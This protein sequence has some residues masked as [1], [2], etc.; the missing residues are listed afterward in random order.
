[1]DIDI[2]YKKNI[3]FYNNDADC[4]IGA[5]LLK[6]YIKNNIGTTPITFKMKSGDRY[7]LEEVDNNTTIWI[8]GLSIQEEDMEFMNRYTSKVKWFFNNDSLIKTTLTN[9]DIYNNID[10]YSH[11]IHNKYYT[12]QNKFIDDFVKNYKYYELIINNLSDVESLY[13]GNLISENEITLFDNIRDRISYKVM[14]NSYKKEYEKYTYYIIY[15]NCCTEDVIEKILR[16][17]DTIIVTYTITKM[18]VINYK[19]YSNVYDLEALSINVGGTIT[20]NIVI[21]NTDT[22]NT[23]YLDIP[24]ML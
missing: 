22:M 8:I 21:A 6:Q 14:L 9:Y 17:R 20:N 24:N 1:M 18:N 5:W 7:R 2:I 16:T 23:L 12:K 11:F 15:D 4:I 19:V 3:V 13:D 10:K